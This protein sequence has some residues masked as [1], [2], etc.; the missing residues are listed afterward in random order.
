[1]S[2]AP[3]KY[4]SSG[5]QNDSADCTCTISRVVLRLWNCTG[6]VG[7]VV[8]FATGYIFSCALH[9]S[10]SKVRELG[11][12]WN[13]AYWW[14]TLPGSLATTTT[15]ITFFFPNANNTTMKI[16]QCFPEL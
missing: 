11:V 10:Q 13:D 12:C 8:L 4:V 1:M 15:Y 6:A 14:P 9:I 5:K 16:G 3:T 2:N 7:Q